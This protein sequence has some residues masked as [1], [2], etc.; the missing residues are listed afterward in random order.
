MSYYDEF[1]NHIQ[2]VQKTS[3]KLD[4]LFGI[5]DDIW[6]VTGAGGEAP[7]HP[8]RAASLRD[9]RRAEPTG[10]NSEVFGGSPISIAWQILSHGY[11]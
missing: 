6:D 4:V 11:P 2:L 10:R 8:S 3:R 5:F 9:S 1:P 7:V